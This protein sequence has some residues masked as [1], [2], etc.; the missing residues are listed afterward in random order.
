MFMKK[1]PTK[2]EC[3]NIIIL[4]LSFS[5]IQLFAHG[6]RRFWQITY[7]YEGQMNTRI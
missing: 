7:A 2:L 4:V 6:H 3:L 1:F 5:L